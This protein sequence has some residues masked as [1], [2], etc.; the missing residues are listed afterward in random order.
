LFYL[1]GVLRDSHIGYALIV[2]IILLPV[3]AEVG[4][5]LVVAHREAGFPAATVQEVL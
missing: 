3:I 4:R 2:I 1:H 5:Q